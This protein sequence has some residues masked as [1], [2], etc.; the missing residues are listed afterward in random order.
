MKVIY[1]GPKSSKFA[2]LLKSNGIDCRVA[3]KWQTYRAKDVSED[4][5]WISDASRYQESA[6][7]ISEVIYKAKLKK[8]LQIRQQHPCPSCKSV[9]TRPAHRPTYLK[10]LSIITLSIS[11]FFEPHG[12]WRCCKCCSSRW[13]IEDSA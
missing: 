9:D 13:L 1:R 8:E 12:Y 11:W 5:L 2:S 10:L 3:A 6:K 4:E 7:L